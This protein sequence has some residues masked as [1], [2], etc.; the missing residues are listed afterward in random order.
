MKGME[1]ERR[2]TIII[3]HDVV[4]ALAFL[5]IFIY[6]IFVFC[7]VGVRAVC[8]SFIEKRTFAHF[9]AIT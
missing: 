1:W 7:S 6:F 3:L 4:H 8:N 9:G 2:E 5:C